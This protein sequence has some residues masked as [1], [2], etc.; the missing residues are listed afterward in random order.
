MLP[1][2]GCA[3]VRKEARLKRVSS[4]HSVHHSFSRETVCDRKKKN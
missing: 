1:L 3:E 4:F 2:A